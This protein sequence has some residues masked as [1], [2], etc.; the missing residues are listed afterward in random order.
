MFAN[1]AVNT[2]SSKRDD[3]FTYEIPEEIR[4][5]IRVGQLVIIPLGPRKVNGIV[6]EL[7]KIK[8]TF[9]TKKIIKIVD[10]TRIVDENKIELARFISEYYWCGFSQALFSF[11]PINL[12]KRKTRIFKNIESQISNIQYPISNQCPITNDQKNIPISQYPNISNLTLTSQQEKALNKI[13]DAI[14]DKKQKTFLLHGVTNSGKT[15]VYLRAFA[16]VLESGGQGIYIVPEIALT[17][18]AIRRFEEV[19]GKEQVALIHSGLSISERLKTWID[20]KTGKKNIVVGSRSAIFTP[21][22]NLKLVVVDEEHD[23]I[24]FKSDQTPRYELHRVAEKLAEIT[25]S[26]LVFGSAT[27]LVTSYAKVLDGEWEYLSLPDRIGGGVAPMVKIINMEEESKGGSEIFSEYLLQALELVLKNK[28]QAL[29]FLN[30]RGMASFIICNDCKRIS[31]CESCD[32]ALVYHSVDNK[33]WCHHCGRKYPVPVKCSTCGGLDFRFLGRGTEKIES[34]IKRYFPSARIARMDR[35][36]MK[37]DLA[38]QSIF[39]RFKASE[40]DILIGTQM[41]VHGWDI[42][43]VDLAAVISIDE[44]LL[45]PDYQAQEK[46]FELLMQ[47]AGR[48]GRSSARGM[49]I[50]QTRSPDLWVFN[51][52][53][54]NDYLT[55]IKR[56]LALR[57][58]FSYPP[59]GRLI[60]L[61]LG[62]VNK[63]LVEK[64]AEE[65]KKI[66]DIKILDIGGSGINIIGPIA[67]LVEKKYGRWW[68]NII[69]KYPIS[70]IQ[71]PMIQSLR[72]DILKAVPKEW[73]IDVDPLT[74]L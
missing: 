43:A 56:E 2:K 11:L 42:P 32:S 9:P 50:L 5:A 7:E 71:Y 34:E 53:R 1:I 16:K 51:C 15:E 4:G 25:D 60:K 72:N 57:E 37:D 6:I 41:I 28:K 44:S 45:L 38:Y 12:R 3:L 73:V 64:K 63:E 33:L 30:R 27:P 18:Q 10:E 65:L 26:I 46:V 35:D 8:P 13:T 40:I 22:Q 19:F 23:L 54:K 24:S 70:N 49:M 68:K 59:F 67:P 29:L 21:L 74:L 20:I 14:E 69:I 61:S 39:D 17:P 58:K 47:L 36:T 62:G 48:A 66:L 55:F 52:V 31:V